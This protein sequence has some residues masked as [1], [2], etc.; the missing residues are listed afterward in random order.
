M[1][2][3]LNYSSFTYNDDIEINT[4]SLNFTTFVHEELHLG[5]ISTPQEKNYSEQW[6]CVFFNQS[7]LDA[8]LKG[9]QMITDL[10]GRFL[11]FITEG[12]RR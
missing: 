3:W 12:K 6:R 5:P 1:K 2:Q 4:T 11:Y 8:P 10:N 9:H 7:R